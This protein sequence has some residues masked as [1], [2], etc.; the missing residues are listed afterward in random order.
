MHVALVLDGD[1]L[2][3]AALSALHDA[4]VVICADGGARHVRDHRT[5][6][7]VVGDGDGLDD[8]TRAWL[9]HAG[10]PIEGHPVAKDH[11]DGELGFEAA[12]ARHPG[13]LSLL[14]GHG[15]RTAMFL[16]NLKLLRRAAEAGI[17]ALMLGHNERIRC[18]GPD[19]AAQPVAGRF[20]LLAVSGDARVRIAG[21]A[22][23]GELVLEGLAAR[24]VSNQ[25]RDGAHV[26]VEHGVVLLI[27]EP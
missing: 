15:G 11:T 17:E 9:S 1:G 14:A 8:A 18:L 7:L 12:L 10:V 3:G 24:G 4:D 22:W 16:A 25:A 13:T 19:Q 26:A 20:S 2:D 23:D 21:A 5:P 27:E 6:D